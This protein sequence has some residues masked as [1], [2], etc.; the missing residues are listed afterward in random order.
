[1]VFVAAAHELME[2]AST[3]APQ[4]VTTRV[5]CSRLYLITSVDYAGPISLRMRQPRSKTITK[6]VHIE[7]VKAYPQKHFLLP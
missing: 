2:P 6:S 1:M 7:V 4:R 5:Q 3:C